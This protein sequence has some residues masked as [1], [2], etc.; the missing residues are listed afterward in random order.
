MVHYKLNTTIS[1]PG[2]SITFIE[3][4]PD[5]QFLAVG[6]RTLSSL[7]IIDK[8][9][10]FHPTVSVVTPAEPTALIWEST[11]SFYVG[12]GDGR[13]VHY[14]IDLTSRKLVEG[15]INT[16]FHGIFPI[17]AIALDAGSKTLV[18]SVG[19]DVLAFRRIRATSLFCLRMNWFNRLTLLKVPSPSLPIFQIAS[20]SKATPGSR[21]PHSQDLSASPPTI[22]L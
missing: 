15:A 16:H 22:W 21:L 19:L 17:T 12:L 9:A 5:G 3:F 18:L 8:L 2:K 13:F 11:K 20:I 14:R 6:D 7:F 4:S 10:G 1:S